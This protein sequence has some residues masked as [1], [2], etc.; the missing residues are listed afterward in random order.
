MSDTPAIV[1]RRPRVEDAAALAATMSDPAVARQLLQL[2]HGTEAHWRAR[3]QD[4]PAGPATADL[5]LVA[6]WHGEVVGNAGLTSFAAVRRRHA[7]GLGLAVATHAQGHGVGRALMAAVIDWAD[8]WAQVLRI[9]LT[10]YTDN[11]RAIALYRSFGF[12]SEGVH[13][14]FALRDGVY[15]DALAMARLR[16]PPP[17]PARTPE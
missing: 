5:F 11:E 3:I 16:P 2:P 15:V 12:E 8:H 7:M 10:V 4:M 1:V 9:E 6:E 17:W 13:R 14:A